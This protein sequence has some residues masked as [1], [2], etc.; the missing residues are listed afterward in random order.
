M[1]IIVAGAWQWSWYEPVCA[2]ALS[3]LGHNVKRFS[4]AERFVHFVPER[5]EP[6]P[7]S[8][9]TAFQ[10]RLVWGP[11]VS[12]MNNDLIKV[13]RGFQPQVL[14]A[15]RATHFFP[16]TLRALKRILPKTLLVQHCNDDP[17]SPSASK[18]LWRHLVSAI[19]IYDMHFVYRH[20][21]IIDFKNAGGKNVKLLRS[22][23]IPE[24]DY[25]VSVSKNSPYR[26]DVVFA[27]HYENDWRV[28]CLEAAMEHGCRL[29]L[30]GGGW[31]NVKL[32]LNPSSPLLR[33][34]PIEPVVG[35]NYRKAISGAKIALC[36][37]S[38]LNRDTYT[39][40]NFEIPAMGTF[41]LS[42]YS[43]DLANLFEEGREI[44]FFRSRDELI[45]KI[46]YYLAHDTE[47]EEIARLGRERLFQDGHDVLSRMKQMLNQIQRVQGVSSA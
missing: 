43:D 25:A 31:E 24:K 26:C 2:E 23:Y 3:R 4:W 40:R 38:K 27:G 6:I 34:F 39:R 12:A 16:S 15:Y 30:F 35:E 9:I 17:F 8:T 21:N 32:F 14:F 46:G 33:L 10:N 47:R 7:Y 5:V 19:P 13:V 45:D 18:V 37:L 28:D 20:H 11:K 42:E 44:E 1:R 22:Y 41:M 36:F 29:N